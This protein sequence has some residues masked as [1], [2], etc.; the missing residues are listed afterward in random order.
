MK[1]IKTLNPEPGFNL[2]I[3][4]AIKWEAKKLLD[5]PYLM[6]LPILKYQ[7]RW[8]ILIKELKTI[9]IMRKL[10]KS[11]RIFILLILILGICSTINIFLPQGDF[12]SGFELPASKGIVALVSFLNVIL[13][14]GGLGY[15]GLRLSR[16]IGFPEIIDEK[17]T[18]NQRFIIPIWVGVAIGIFFIGADMIFLKFHDYGSMP[19][20]PFPTSIIASISAGIGEENIFRLFFISF[21]V[22]L[23]SKVILK[24]KA[25]N[26]VFWI[27]SVLSAIG[28]A[29]GHLPSVLMILDVESINDIAPA[30]LLEVLI[31][32][33]VLSIFAA[34][35][36]RKYGFLAAV[37]IH[38]WVDIVWHVIYGLF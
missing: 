9:F 25:F 3:F 31:L 5:L 15:L 21:W 19:H 33:G 17:V 1:I 2:D 23:V 4:Y 30:I 8:L 34:Y 18:T 29:A 22:W 16:I 38:F 6:S 37:G 26:T 28:F 24:G 7:V 10:D 12:I 27:I 13:I 20:P 36:F 14:Y 35:Y 32:N 11:T